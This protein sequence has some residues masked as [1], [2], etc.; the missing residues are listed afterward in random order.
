MTPD[1]QTTNMWLA[2]LAVAGAV[3]TLLLLAAAIGLFRMY[4]ST[5]S[6]LQRSKSVIWRRSVRVRRSSWTTCRTSP[7]ARVASTTRCARSCRGWTR[8]PE[9]PK[10]W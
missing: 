7:R 9:S 2:I 1:L 5:V 4:R 10:T 6:A 3:Q 8:R